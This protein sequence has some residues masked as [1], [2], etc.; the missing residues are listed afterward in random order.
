[1]RAPHQ[2]W[3]ECWRWKTILKPW[4]K[5]KIR[6]ESVDVNLWEILMRNGIFA[7]SRVSPHRVVSEGKNTQWLDNGE[8]RHQFG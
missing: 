3:E 5:D 4:D 6:Q 7:W 1:L 2:K 8:I